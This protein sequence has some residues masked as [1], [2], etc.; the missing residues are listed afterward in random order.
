MMPLPQ[1]WSI[2]FFFMI[3]IL[4]LDTEFVGIE[5][6]MTSFSDIFPT[7]MHWAGRREAFLLFF[8]LMCFFLLLILTTEQPQFGLAVR[9]SHASTSTC[10]ILRVSNHGESWFNGWSSSGRRHAADLGLSSGIWPAD[11]L[12]R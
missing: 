3:I 1:V 5:L 11:L 12:T 7:V 10:S 4:G 6:V 9:N 2:C 8:C